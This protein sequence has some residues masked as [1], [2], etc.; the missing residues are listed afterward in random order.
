MIPL[1]YSGIAD[2]KKIIVN[3]DGK[4]EK[5]KS[6]AIHKNCFIERFEN[7]YYLLC[8]KKLDGAMIK[9]KMINRE[10]AK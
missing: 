4:D 10:K 6:A 7:P 1:S 3:K 5:K 8:R 9:D 2:P